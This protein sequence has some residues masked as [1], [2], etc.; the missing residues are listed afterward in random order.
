MRAAVLLVS[1]LA[2]P[3]ACGP[4]PPPPCEESA[5]HVCRWAGSGEAGRSDD[6]TSRLDARLYSPIDVEFGPDGRAIIVDWNN[7]QLRRVE[8]DGTLTTVAGSELPG[9]GADYDQDEDAAGHKNLRERAVAGLPALDIGLNHPTDVVFLPDGRLLLASWHNHKLRHFE[10]D[11]GRA[12]LSCGGDPGFKGDGASAEFARLKWPRALAAAPDGTVFLLDQA[13]QRIRRIG[14]DGVITTVAGNGTKGFGGD[15]GDPRLASFNFE[16]GQNPLPSGA[17]A[18]DAAG[19]LYVGDA[20]NHRIRRIDLEANTIE[21]IAGTGEDG[22]SGDGGPAL[23]ARFGQVRD[24]EFGPD[25]RL[26]F[27]DSDH[28]RVRAIDLASGLVSN[29][30]GT[31]VSGLGAD[32]AAVG[33]FALGTPYGLGF[34]EAGALFVAELE[35]HRI[36]KVSR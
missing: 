7:H 30:V 5:G 13:N 33:E 35:N 19:R 34:D 6:G 8:A 9:D 22:D 27:S 15:G 16:I 20:L 26:Y 12:H 25:G 23:A 24:L 28:H 11:A 29:V 4:T 2:A 32:G 36:V 21:T 14:P 3:L 17:L 1:M 31:G 10:L 18:R